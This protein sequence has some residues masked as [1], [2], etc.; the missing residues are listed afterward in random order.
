MPAPRLMRAQ[1]SR[2]HGLT[3]FYRVPGGLRVSWVPPR[4]WVT[5]GEA[6]RALGTYCRLLERMV[7]AGRLTAAR[8]EG[9][10]VLSVGTVRA[11]RRAW[12]GRAASAL[13]RLDG[14]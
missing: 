8:R 2:N 9:R 7:D 11:L 1:L 6:A 3:L 5:L 4:G 13:T 10:R 12:R 14:K